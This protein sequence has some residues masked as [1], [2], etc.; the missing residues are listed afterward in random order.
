MT[1]EPVIE[2]SGQIGTVCTVRDL[3]ELREIEAVARERQS[4]LEHVLESARENIA[5][6]DPDGRLDVDQQ[7]G[8]DD[9]RL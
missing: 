4:L 9:V 3:S 5:A 8:R 2:E 1:A 6:T 7:R